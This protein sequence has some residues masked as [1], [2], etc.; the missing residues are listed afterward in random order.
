MDI[1]PQ[2]KRDAIIAAAADHFAAIGF[3]NARISDIARQAEIGK[4]TVYEYFRSKEALLLEAC[5]WCCDT[6][7]QAVAELVGQV[8][9]TA[10]VCALHRLVRAVLEVWPTRNQPYS[11]LFLD[12]WTI[13]R[14]QPVMLAQ[15]RERLQGVYQQQESAIWQLILAGEKAGLLRVPGDAQFLC[16]C[17]TACV[18][19]FTWQSTFRADLG[20]ERIATDGA[21]LFLLLILRE[22]HRLRELCPVEV[23]RA[24]SQMEGPCVS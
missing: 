11:R 9:Q 10:P 3:S 18:D 14:D 4:G 23:S 6:S 5:L 15:A 12:L 24:V 8:D 17:F 20:P 22:P 1:A 13:A 16:R 2:P 21:D 19:G 7:R